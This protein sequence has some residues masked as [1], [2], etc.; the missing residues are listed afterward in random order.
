MTRVVDLMVAVIVGL[1][2]LGGLRRG[3]RREL[4]N[5]AGVVVAVA[6]G[7][8]LAKPVASLIARLG[9]LEEVPYLLAFI[10]GFLAASLLF[11]LL[12]APLLARE[13]DLAERISGG[14]VGLAKG[15]VLAAVLLYLVIG[16]W[17]ASGGAL[18]RG[19]ATRMVV[20]VTG[21]VD[22]AAGVL[23]VLLPEN[24]SV[25]VR[26]AW[27]GVREAGREAE[28]A[29]ETMREAGETVRAYGEQVEAGAALVDSLLKPP[30]GP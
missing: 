22:R 14:V 9:V 11:S 30:P 12:K 1:M 18:T 28:E 7:I 5:L 23:R 15:V 6:G 27:E 24:F 2:V 29:V 19:P 25:R 3:L 20:P 21:L 26:T 8:F 4:L 17:P 10:G 13:I 16:I